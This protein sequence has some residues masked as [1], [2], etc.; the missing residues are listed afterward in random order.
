[1]RMARVEAPSLR[2]F[3][4]NAVAAAVFLGRIA[5]ACF[6]K[7]GHGTSLGGRLAELAGRSV[8][9]ATASQLTTALALI[10]LDGCARRIVILP[11]D[12]D[13]AN[14]AAVIARGRDR[15]RRGR[16]RIAARPDL[17][18]PVRVSCASAVVPADPNRPAGCSHRMAADDLWA[19]PG[20][21]N[22]SCMI[23]RTLRGSQGP[24]RRRRGRRMGHVLRH[25]P[26]RRLANV[27]SRGTRR[28]LDGSFQRRRTHRG[29]SGT[30]CPAWRHPSLRHALTLASCADGSGDPKHRAAL[31]QALRERSP[32]SR[33]STGCARHFRKPRSAT[34]MLRPKPASPLMSTMVL[35][36]FLPPS[37]VRSAT[38]WK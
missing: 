24:Q 10:E 36:A 14:L 4:A 7:L 32:T 15:C 25:P 5:S 30:S 11:P 38:A 19:R 34:L 28:R 9:L 1:M 18:L 8:L 2:D 33:S 13:A 35:P 31:R 27:S 26:L 16:W 6:T 21:R 12:V 29:S 23:S 37:S 3:V 17:D 20:S 22:W